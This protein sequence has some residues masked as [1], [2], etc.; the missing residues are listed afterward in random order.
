MYFKFALHKFNDCHFLYS[1]RLMKSIVQGYQKLLN[2]W[3]WTFLDIFF[4]TE[5]KSFEKLWNYAEW[6]PID[7]LSS[8]YIIIKGNLRKG[9]QK[10]MVEFS[11]KNMHFIQLTLSW[12]RS[13]S[14]R[15]QSTDLLCKPMDWFRNDMDLRHKRV[16]LHINNQ[17]CSW[18]TKF[19]IRKNIIHFLFDFM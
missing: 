12:Q 14:Y 19:L 13:L 1:F 17:E 4:Y 15:N 3:V 2:L 11:N 18:P 6:D 8:T 16:I 7:Y 5:N 10:N 9:K